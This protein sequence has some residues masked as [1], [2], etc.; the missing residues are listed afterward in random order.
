MD[1]RYP[2]GDFAMEKDVTPAKRQQAITQIA[3]APGQLRAAVSNL[4][5]T[6]LDT[7]YRE[8]GWTVRQLVHHVA[9]SHLNAYIRFRLAMTEI[10]PTIKPYDEK[11]WAELADAKSMAVSVSLDL[12]EALHARWDT[13]L[14]ATKEADFART[15]T[16]PEHGPRTANWLVFLYAWHGRHHTA[17]ITELRKA[18]GW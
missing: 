9:D 4:D 3:E 8:G 5:N 10:A 17:H 6:Q 14:A 2:I 13:L 7:P 15:L 18:R 12:L 11:M 16:H 1:S